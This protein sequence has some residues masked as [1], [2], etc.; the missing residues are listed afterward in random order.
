MVGSRT[1][2]P[3][4]EDASSIQQ[5]KAPFPA[6][7]A[8]LG[9]AS[10]PQEVMPGLR[11]EEERVPWRRMGTSNLSSRPSSAGIPAGPSAQEGNRALKR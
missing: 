6:G 2:L 3:H 5:E 7:G 8:G 9:N 11:E 10:L 4:G 1:P